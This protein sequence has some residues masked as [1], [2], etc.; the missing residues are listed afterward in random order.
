MA[1][2]N[3]LQELADNLEGAVFFAFKKGLQR[4][5]ENIVKELQE[6]GPT[7]SG[8]FANSW[9]IASAS[10][11]SSGS[12]APGR[13]QPLK[14][15]LLTNNE[16]KFKP[17]VKY[18][19]ANKAPY[20][21]YALDLKEGVFWPEGEP[22][23]NRQVVKSGSRPSNPHKRGAVSAGEGNA[24]SSAELDWYTTYLQGRQIDRTIS[25]YM[26]QALRE[27]RK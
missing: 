12:G 14:A 8:R 22:L 3:G 5:A 13:P 7:W 10:Q 26:D 18:Y 27:I 15:P 6:K 19:I 17:E 11:V 25:L 1:R 16:F 24:T 23:A 9:E 2:R 4:S 21:D 20:A